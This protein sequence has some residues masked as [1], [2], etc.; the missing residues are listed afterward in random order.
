MSPPSL[1]KKVPMQHS[2][3]LLIKIH[4]ITDP[5]H[6]EALGVGKICTHAA[7]FLTALLLCGFLNQ[8]S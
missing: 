5:W 8:H 3:Q 7:S 1:V 6:G 4:I 2:M